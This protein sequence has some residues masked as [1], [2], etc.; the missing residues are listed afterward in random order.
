MSNYLKLKVNDREL[1]SIRVSADTVKDYRKPMQQYLAYLEAETKQQF[2]TQTAPDGKRWKDLSKRTWERKKTKAILR[3]KSNMI[4]TLYTK[5]ISGGGEIGFGA[6]YTIYHQEGTKKMA[7]R[8]ILEITE[9][10]E[11]RGVQ[12]FESY[13][14]NELGAN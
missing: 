4:N 9:E 5:L 12:I 14:G 10:R 13:Y 3:E 1:S 8:K 7:Q 6:E 2:I 11:A